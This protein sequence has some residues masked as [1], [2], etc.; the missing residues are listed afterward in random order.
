MSGA[1]AGRVLDLLRRGGWTLAVAES[2]T[3]GLVG[4]AVTDVPGSSASFLGG[5]IAYDDSVKR[6]VLNVPAQL[7]EGAGA[8]SGAAVEAMAHGLRGIAGADVC[9][10]V[11]GIAGPTGARPGKPVGLVWMAVLGPEH[12][13]A[14]H[15][16]SFEGDRASVRRQAVDAALGLV[17]SNLEQALADAGDAAAG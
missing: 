5:V 9:I 15:R 1:A 10:A 13:L 4:A 2:C 3:G 16:F 14:V 11:S 17:E 7:L 8:V 12:L 6:D